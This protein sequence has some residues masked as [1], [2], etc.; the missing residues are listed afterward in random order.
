MKRV[1][2]LLAIVGMLTSFSQAALIGWEAENG[3][4]F[5]G[6]VSASLG[7]D[8]DPALSD[9]VALGGSYITTEV[10]GGSNTP[11]SDSRTVSYSIDF[12]EAGNYDLYARLYVEGGNAD[13]SMFY[14]REF[15]DADPTKDGGTGYIGWCTVNGIADDYPLGEYVWI[16]LSTYKSPF[17]ENPSSFTVDSADTYNWEFG[18]REDGLRIDALAFGTSGESF[19]DAQLNTAVTGVPEPATMAL[20][21]LGGLV[22]SRKR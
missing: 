3:S 16:N 1:F 2:C 15:G 9:A 13:D 12:T 21:G 20:L 7:S 6:T 8:F 19:T 10:G 22:L 17:G 4:S 14:A 18:A 5:S 11:G